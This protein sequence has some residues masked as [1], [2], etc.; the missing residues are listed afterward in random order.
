MYIVTYHCTRN[1]D[2]VPNTTVAGIEAYERKMC[3]DEAGE[4]YV[5]TNK[6]NLKADS[7]FYT[8]TKADTVLAPKHNDDQSTC[9]HDW[10]DVSA[11][12][13]YGSLACVRCNAC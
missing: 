8:V 6:A 3:A 4:A 2:G 13:Q 11:P 12:G 9:R 10:I 5:K 7:L 1:I